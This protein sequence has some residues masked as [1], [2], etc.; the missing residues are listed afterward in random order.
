MNSLTRSRSR[1]RV[2]VWFRNDLRLLDNPTLTAATAEVLAERQCHGEGSADL[3]CIY[4][5]DPRHYAMTPFGHR[6]TAHH[7][8]NFLIQAVDDL[9]RSLQ[10][11]G[12]DLVVSWQKPEVAI[13]GLCTAERQ[14]VMV[15]VAQEVAQEEVDV[16]GEV[17]QALRRRGG[18][19]RLVRVPSAAWL[20]HPE[21]APF[22]SK[23]D[24]PR[25]FTPF[26]QRIQAA[27][28]PIRPVLPH[29]P[30]DL[31][32]GSL[33]D[34]QEK[35]QGL[36]TLRDLGFSAEEEEEGRKPVDDRSAF[37]LGGGESEGLARVASW[38]FARNLLKDYFD[39]R[40]GMIGA[41]YSSKL[42]PFLAIGCLSPRFLYY[43]VKRYEG[44]HGVS[45]GSDWF[46]RELACRDYF[47]YF[48]WKHGSKMFFKGGVLS[49]SKKPS[50]AAKSWRKDDEVIRRWK[51]G[52][53]GMP[54]VDANMRELRATG[55]MSNRGR[56]NVASYFTLDLHQDWRIGADHFESLL[57]DYD[58]CS[59]YANW[60]AAAGLT[61]GR[62]NHFNITKQ[63]HDYDRNGDYIRLWV[64]ELRRIPAPLIF[65]PWKLST[66]E[67]HRYGVVLGSD[68]PLPVEVPSTSKSVT[69]HAKQ[70]SG[71]RRLDRVGGV[72][73]R[74]GNSHRSV[75]TLSEPPVED[76]F[77]SEPPASICPNSDLH[78]P[79]RRVQHHW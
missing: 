57:L 4:C 13:P 19:S 39:I 65:E 36:P 54:L 5:F 31:L 61:G 64:P 7:R 78:H 17:E 56:Q 79:F 32:A 67:Q 37:K 18:G 29:P 2:V 41:D 51:E 48:S 69:G 42:S 70:F 45:K 72:N 44:E 68:Y 60:N 14:P 49:S 59:N 40:N 77:P 47:R 6:K 23:E 53:T 20:F 73:Q 11:V 28:T 15:Y 62:I 25:P 43:E 52:Q 50:A 16:E 35:D 1:S 3:V 38:M 21:D 9:K 71:D 66:D 10:A 46:I 26:Y 22:R 33:L 55:W 75:Q 76:H 63:S 74:A 58:V 12:S 34:I 30:R 24:L 8:A 27:A